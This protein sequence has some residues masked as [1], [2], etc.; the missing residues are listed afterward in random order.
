M[1]L[2]SAD[3][4]PCRPLEPPERDE[5]RIPASGAATAPQRVPAKRHRR[6]EVP[7]CSSEDNGKTGLFPTPS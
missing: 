2:P 7:P 6:A 5:G 3:T 1:A 4:S